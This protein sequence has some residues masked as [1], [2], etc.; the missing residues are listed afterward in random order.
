MRNRSIDRLRAKGRRLPAADQVIHSIDLAPEATSET[1]ALHT[2]VDKEQAESLKQAVGSLPE[3]QKRAIEL[4][5]FR[6]L[7]HQEIA[8]TLGESLGTVK[9]RIRYGLSKL[10]N[11]VKEGSSHE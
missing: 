8:E 7:S 11:L 6:G 5:F 4:A 9:S 1:T 3:E 2:L 10:R